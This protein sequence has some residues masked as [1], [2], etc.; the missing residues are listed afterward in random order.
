MLSGEVLTTALL[1]IALAVALYFLH[2]TTKS[3]RIA[4]AT[5]SAYRNYPVMYHTLEQTD[6]PLDA[7]RCPMCNT[8]NGTG[9][10][11]K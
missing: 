6:R 9:E 3:L 4:K 11:Y 8:I 1:S 7:I 10:Q 5:L 2:R